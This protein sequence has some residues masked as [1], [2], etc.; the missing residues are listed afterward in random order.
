MNRFARHVLIVT[1]AGSLCV[2]AGCKRN[3]ETGATPPSDA[4]ASAP[5]A[6]M[7]G[8]VSAPSAASAP[9]GASQ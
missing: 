5:V 7:P 8:V 6:P 1:L 9:S 4:S 3:T 2:V